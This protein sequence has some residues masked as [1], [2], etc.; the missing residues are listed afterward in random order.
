MKALYYLIEKEFKQMMRN[1]LLPILFVLLPIVL[2]NSLPR[3]ATQ[4]IKNLKFTVVDCDHSSSSQRLIQ[5]LSA[6]P[7]FSLACSYNTYAEAMQDIQSGESDIIVVIEPDFERHLVC[8]NKAI[9]QVSANGVNGVKAGLGTGYIAQLIN[10]FSSDVLAENGISSP[11]ANNAL[12]TRVVFNPALDYK[13]YMVPAVMAMLVVLLV[14]FLPALNIV[15]EKEKGTIEQINVTPVGRIT[16]IFSKLIPYWI[17][18]LLIIVISL[19]AGKIIFDI[20]PQGSL[21]AILFVGTIFILVMSSLG[22]IVSN[23]S[24]TLQ[25]AAL[26]AYFFLVI[27]ILMSG[28]LT[29]IA[30]M[31]VWAQ[32]LTSVNPFR[33]IIASLRILYIRQV[34]L[35]EIWPNVWPLVVFGIISGTWA[36]TSYKKSN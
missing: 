35:S 3:L 33:Y 16:F 27:C 22:L 14:G 36:I 28:L 31:P 20:F 19:L 2:T 17:V 4:E 8:D 15:S 23:Y 11:L 13:I 12:S 10:D 32:Y 1:R 6:S 18:G 25:Q 21:F 24:S 34:G 9:V 7:Y 30:S 26:L 5:K 29:P